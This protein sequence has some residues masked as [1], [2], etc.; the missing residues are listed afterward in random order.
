MRIRHIKIK[1]YRGIKELEAPLGSDFICFIGSGDCRKSSILSAIETFLTHYSDN[2]DDSDLFDGDPGNEAIIELTITDYPIGFESFNNY[3]E[4]LRGWSPQELKIH[5]E[6]K[7]GDDKAFTIR[8]TIDKNLQKQWAV[9]SERNNEG[10]EFKR[11][12]QY[13]LNAIRIGETSTYD[14]SWSRN[15]LLHRLSEEESGIGKIIADASRAARES[16]K[17]GLPKLKEAAEKVGEAAKK[18]GVFPRTGFKPLLD[19]GRLFSGT[20]AGISLHDGNVPLRRFGAGSRRLVLLSMQRELMRHDCVVLADELEYGLEP[21]RLRALITALKPATAGGETHA[22]AFATTHSTIAIQAIPPE[23]LKVVRE[24]A[25]VVSIYDVPD[26]LRQ[27]ARKFPNALLG[28]K[29]IVGEGKTEVGF[30]V[31]LDA[32][33]WEKKGKAGINQLGVVPINGEGQ[34]SA[35]RFAKRLKGLGYDTALLAD[36]D[37]PLSI[38][39]DDLEKEG[40]ACFLWEDDTSIEERISLDLPNDKLNEAIVL[41]KSFNSP[42]K[43][44]SSLVHLRKSLGLSETGTDWPD[45]AS[46]RAALGKLMKDEEWFKDFDKGE[47]LGTLVAKYFEAVKEKALGKNLIL[48][49]KW[50]DAEQ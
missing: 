45:E 25:G 28:K 34:S 41:A 32:G 13:K 22:Q 11:R 10:L 49:R 47:E 31:G 16:A 15:S 48:L 44:D 42:S 6:P 5:D 7:D 21:H 36:T 8:L 1:N 30:I 18:L 14:F 4:Q 43:I 46:A 50:I 9:V 24:S 26:E 39:P 40:V 23:H 20:K 29:I 17:D 12:D 19:S 33:H 2:L 3:A 38:K 37:V 27:V 35:P